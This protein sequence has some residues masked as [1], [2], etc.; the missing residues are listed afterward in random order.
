MKVRK[1]LPERA[2]PLKAYR[3]READVPLT[4]KANITTPVKHRKGTL[5][6]NRRK[7][8]SKSSQSTP[9]KGKIRRGVKKIHG[10]KRRRESGRSDWPDLRGGDRKEKKVRP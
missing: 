8:K 5:R 9:E 6:V 3:G 10:R 1:K 2:V 7:K 4:K